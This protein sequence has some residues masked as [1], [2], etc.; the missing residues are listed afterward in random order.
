MSCALN[1]DTSTVA[2]SGG[3][4]P[5]VVG[6]GR[7]AR[8][9]IFGPG[10]ASY[11]CGVNFSMSAHTDS[12]GVHGQQSYSVNGADGCAPYQ[13]N[14]DANVTCLAV[15]GNTA[16]IRGVI[17]HASGFYVG[18]QQSGYSVFVTDVTDNG[19]PS[20]AVRDMVYLTNDADGTQYDCQVPGQYSVFERPVDNGNITVH[21]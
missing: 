10:S 19:P 17:T 4:D 9:A 2:P 18:I 11:S 1:A 13:G 14:V 8:G 12:N 7:Y 20:A 3:S 15:S 16:E 21:D 6:G 5:F